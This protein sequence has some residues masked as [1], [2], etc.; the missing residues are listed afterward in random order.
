MPTTVELGA[1]GTGFF[2]VSVHDNAIDDGDRE[3]VI[4]AS[5]PAGA[6]EAGETT[7]TI[8]DDD[9]MLV[10]GEAVRVASF[11]LLNDTG[12]RGSSSF[13]AVAASLSRIE[14]DVIAFQEVDSINDFGN[15][16]LLLG[17]IAFPHRRRPLCP[18]RRSIPWR[19]LQWWRL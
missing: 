12:D 8:V 7:L 16:K 19:T 2:E 3:V 5:D 10:K 15:L 4:K 13:K 18:G 6:L 1:D 14:P 9:R 17:D 11:N